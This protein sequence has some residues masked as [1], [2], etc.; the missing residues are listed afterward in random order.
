MQN[1]LFSK[2]SL[3]EDQIAL[4]KWISSGLNINE[5]RNLKG[6]ASYLLNNMIAKFI[7]ASP[8]YHL[9]KSTVISLE[10]EKINFQRRYK[11]SRFYG[12]SKSPSYIYEH[13]IPC[14]LVRRKLMKVKN[15]FE[16]HLEVLIQAGKVVM[17]TREEDDKL[18]SCGLKS[19]MPPGWEWG[20]NNFDRYKKAGIE[21]STKMLL[22]EG[23]ICR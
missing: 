3:N 12:R 16:S 15:D 19:A 10:K 18:N 23:S 20:H 8:A 21:L 5:V 11:R 4:A 7:S 1:K 13:S 22:V 9:S 2:I 6:D 17:V 14:S